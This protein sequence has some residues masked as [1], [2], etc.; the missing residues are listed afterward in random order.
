MYKD[1][2][3]KQHSQVIC[4]GC[5]VGETISE[6]SMDLKVTNKITGK[7]KVLFREILS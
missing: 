1:G 2:E 6:E 4:P 7:L 3:I 5:V